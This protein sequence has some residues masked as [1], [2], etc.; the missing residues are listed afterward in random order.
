MQITGR[1][2]ATVNVPTININVTPDA[3]VA[4]NVVQIL[5][6]CTTK[7]NG[8]PDEP[9]GLVFNNNGDKLLVS[10]FLSAPG[11]WRY[12]L[13]AIN[14][15]GV[16]L[17]RGHMEVEC[18]PLP[19]SIV[20]P[21]APLP[22]TTTVINNPP[23]PTANQQGAQNMTTP[24]ATPWWQKAL[25]GASV[26]AILG[27]VA[28]ALML[29]VSCAG[30]FSWLWTDGRFDTIE[31]KVDSTKE[32]VDQAADK[33]NKNH[34]MTR[35]VVKTADEN[36]SGRHFETLGAVNDAR[37]DVKKTVNQRADGLEALGNENLKYSKRSAWNSAA[38][39]KAASK[40]IKVELVE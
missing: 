17:D 38:A 34:Q 24:A 40:P 1:F 12:D 28:I 7:P 30:L 22:P 4:S 31:A 35:E 32:A 20:A 13:E 16:V 29:F 27:G 26:T 18:I 5:R 33:D 14:A 37:D 6:V 10:G 11:K 36:N 3:S 21:P 25:M 39:R 9:P 15:A 2:I 23:H 8:Q 19:T